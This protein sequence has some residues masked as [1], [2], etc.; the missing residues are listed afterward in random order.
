MGPSIGRNGTLISSTGKI[1]DTSGGTI[2]LGVQGLAGKGIGGGGEIALITDDYGSGVIISPMVV[3][4][5]IYEASAG[6][7]FQ[8][9]SAECMEELEGLS[10]E[11]VGVNIGILSLSLGFTGDIKGNDPIT[12]ME[13]G[14]GPGFGFHFNGIEKSTVIRF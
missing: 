2:A 4:P 13:I 11:W 12:I 14:F 1:I 10:I 7:F 3:T 8:Y 6:G 9:S 5:I